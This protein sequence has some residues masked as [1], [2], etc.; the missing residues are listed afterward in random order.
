MI[1]S[2]KDYLY[3][4][5]MDRKALGMPG[6]KPPFFGAENWKYEIALRK[7]EYLHNC[8]PFLWKFR[9]LFNKFQRHYLGILCCGY[10]IPLNAFEEGLAIIHLGPV[11][12]NEGVKVGHN[13]KIVGTT[14]IGA[15]NGQTAAPTIG[16]NVFIGINTSI[17]GNITIGDNAAIGANALC[18]KD[19]PASVTVG[20]VPAKI[21]SNND[22]SSNLTTLDPY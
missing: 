6:T 22:S 18:I 13:C 7:G 20:G 12:V 10:S 15:T 8:K 3:Y 14:T 11:I 4:L 2:K 16:N 21:I 19:V 5:E 17:L 1:T 9:A